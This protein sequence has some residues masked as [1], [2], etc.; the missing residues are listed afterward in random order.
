[1]HNNEKGFQTRSIIVII[2]VIFYFL[3]LNYNFITARPHCLQC[4]ALY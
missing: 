4:R 2:T 1:M 3:H